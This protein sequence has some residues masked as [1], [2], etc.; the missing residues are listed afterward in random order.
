MSW[1]NISQPLH[2][3]IPVW[4]GDTPFSYNLTWDK[5]ENGVVNVGQITM[6]THTGTHLD[7]PFHF[8]DTG[9][10]IDQ[11]DLNL[12]VGP[13]QI[14]HLPYRVID[15]ACVEKVLD[16]SIDRLLICTGSWGERTSFP[17][18]YTYIDPDLGPFLKHRG[19][20]LLGVDTPSVDELES[21][22]LLA[23][24]SLEQNHIFILEGLVLDNIK[25]GIYD[26]IALPL[27]IV[28]ADGSPVRA[29]IRP[30]DIRE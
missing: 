26:L 23:H 5:K 22:D 17:T 30:T 20:K 16:A 7:A 29:I 18:K 25:P 24:H 19:I 28:G 4:P 2:A 13:A 1:I 9:L 6:S 12:F 8:T 3:E 15:V 11:L 21:K 14:V 27:F 10:A